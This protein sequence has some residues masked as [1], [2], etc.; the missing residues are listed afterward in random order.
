MFQRGIYKLPTRYF[1]DWLHGRVV[2]VLATDL[3]CLSHYQVC[4]KERVCLP[5]REKQPYGI[6]PP[7]FS[8]ENNGKKL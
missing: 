8:D 1:Q 3:C 5:V 4:K 6:V 2:E 7:N